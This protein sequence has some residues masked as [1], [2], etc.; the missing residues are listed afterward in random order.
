MLTLIYSKGQDLKPLYSFFVCTNNNQI[1]D[2]VAKVPKDFS[3]QT[4]ILER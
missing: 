1:S 4:E 2:I 3:K